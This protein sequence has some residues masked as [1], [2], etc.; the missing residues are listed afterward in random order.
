MK[1]IQHLSFTFLITLMVA[2]STSNN[3]STTPDDGSVN[4]STVNNDAS[5]TSNTD[6][7]AQPD[8]KSDSSDANLADTND[9]NPAD[10]HDAPTGTLQWRLVAAPEDASLTSVWG[11]DSRNVY[12]ISS[13]KKIKKWSGSG[14]S[15]SVIGGALRSNASFLA[16]HGSDA[17]TIWVVGSWFNS[18]DP[19]VKPFA[20]RWDI[21]ASGFQD[22]SIEMMALSGFSTVF[23]RSP[24]E[25]WAAGYATSKKWNGSM[26]SDIDKPSE[27]FSIWSSASKDV[28]YLG[29]KFVTHNSPD[30]TSKLYTLS[31][32][33]LSS[34]SGVS[35]NDVWA[36]GYIFKMGGKNQRI[37]YKYDS[38]ADTWN[39]AYL[40]TSPIHTTLT[41]IHA[42]SS[43]DVWAVGYTRE[44]VGSDTSGVLLHWN[45]A[46]WEDRSTDLNTNQALNAVYA[47]NA[48]DIWVVGDKGTVFRYSRQ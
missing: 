37:I 27:A 36:A 16:I 19:N 11:A 47:I 20:L 33:N 42:V 34:I 21:T 25:V 41:A 46:A 31:S 7:Q 6:T 39:E 26:W 23:V 35:N 3:S 22:Q 14:W 40:S 32:S 2:C 38:T 45:G 44:M 18:G 30:G 28:W 4:D 24:N 29:G 5:D 1:S 48:E 8:T 17:N 15:D 9:T 43:T 12:V 10:T 13:N